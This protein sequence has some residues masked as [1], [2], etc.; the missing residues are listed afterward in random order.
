[1]GIGVTT[2]QQVGGDESARPVIQESS[3]AARKPRDAEAILFG[4]MFAN[5]QT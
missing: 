1:M 2:V 4:L 5:Q 3:A